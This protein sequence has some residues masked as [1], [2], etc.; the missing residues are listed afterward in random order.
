MGIDMGIEM[1]MRIGMRIGIGMEMVMGWDWDGDSNE[2]VINDMKI[3]ETKSI[4]YLG[5]IIDRKL[6]WIDH[7]TYVKNKVTK[8]IGIIRK[9]RKFC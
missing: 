3:R 9:A 7:I 1:G 4:K 8:G 2:L 5:V 6:N